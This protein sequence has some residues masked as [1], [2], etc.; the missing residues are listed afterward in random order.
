MLHKI[1]IMWT[2]TKCLIMLPN[3]Y[4]LIVDVC[5][6]YMSRFI[7]CFMGQKREQRAIVYMRDFQVFF[8]SLE[9]VFFSPL[10]LLG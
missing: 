10:D 8:L 6:Y 3:W 7:Q 9:R 1:L 2:M 4:G 5:W